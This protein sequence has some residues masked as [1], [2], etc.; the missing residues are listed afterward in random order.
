MERYT[1]NQERMM[2]SFLLPTFAI[3][4]MSSRAF[5]IM[6]LVLC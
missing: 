6:L 1:C 2:M 3:K 4:M 5:A